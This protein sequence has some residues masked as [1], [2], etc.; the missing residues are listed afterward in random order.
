MQKLKKII[1]ILIFILTALCVASNVKAATIK[2]SQDSVEIGKSVTITVSVPNV[3]TVD[4][5]ASVSG[6][7]TSGTIRIVDGSLT[8][9]AKT[10]YKSITVTPTS[11]GT[12]T[13][14]ILS[15]SN[16]VLNGQY[17]DVSGTSTITVTEP[18]PI[19]P[20]SGNSG[21][22]ETTTQQ[23]PGNNQTTTQPKPTTQTQKPA[24]ETKSDNSNLSGL[25]I[26]EGVITPEFSSSIKEYSINVPNEVTK[27][28]IAAVTDSSKATV[29]IVGNEELKVGQ[30]NIDIIV[31]AEDGSKT[32]YKVLATRADK[33]LNLQALTI[34]YAN[35]NGEKTFLNLD[36]VFAMDVYSYKILEEISHVVKNLTVEATAT[37]ENARV[38]I[39]G[40]DELKAGINK[41][42]IKVTSVDEAGLEEQKTYTVEVE[43]KEEPIVV[44]LTT[45]QKIKNIFGGFGKNLTTWISK[46]LSNITKGMLI[47]STI[48]FVGLTIYL[49]YDYKNY[50]KLL[51]KLAEYNKENLMERATVALNQK[52]VNKDIDISK[53]ENAETIEQQEIIEE[54]DEKTKAKQGKGRRFK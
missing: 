45:M 25:Q 23:K 54:Q 33:I 8:G 38:E 35:E 24:Q 11:A 21:C 2:V 10:F 31:T 49:A 44:P 32:T 19:T 41:I 12:I 29:S 27:L 46:N 17:V 40:N 34:Y 6:A 53:T 43:Q 52:A 4:L 48:A 50:Q 5:T 30:N 22:S 18:A 9:E 20:P 16:A 37:K 15:S 36:P 14:S 39:L 47:V 26:A 3:N 1:L 13:V 7:G 51:A 28:S 42:T